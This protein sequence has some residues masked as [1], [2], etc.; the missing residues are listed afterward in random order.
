MTQSSPAMCTSSASRQEPASRADGAPA[1]PSPQQPPGSPLLWRRGQMLSSESL[2]WLR[3]IAV[4]GASLRCPRA[5]QAHDAG[6]PD[7]VHA[8]RLPCGPAGQHGPQPGHAERGAEQRRARPEVRP[9]RPLHLVPPGGGGEVPVVENG[10]VGP[11][12]RL[13]CRTNGRGG[14][15]RSRREASH[16]LRESWARP[17]ASTPQ[18]PHLGAPG[19]VLWGSGGRS[20]AR[21]A[22]RR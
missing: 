17:C 12:E 13:L 4:H 20:P 3:I 18:P 5:G 15:G 11:A 2:R 6:A 19:E 16:R 21:L 10:E 9:D 1:E 22:S 7:R 8:L 14:L